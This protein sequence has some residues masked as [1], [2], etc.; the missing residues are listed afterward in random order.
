MVV[1]Y[2]VIGTLIIVVLLLS[3]IVGYNSRRIS[4]IKGDYPTFDEWWDNKSKLYKSHNGR[5]EM[6]IKKGYEACLAEL[7]RLGKI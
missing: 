6:E 2:S 3:Y 4:N 5:E 7:K 1:A